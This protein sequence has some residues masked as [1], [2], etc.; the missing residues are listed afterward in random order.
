MSSERKTDSFSRR[1]G[2]ETPAG[3][4]REGWTVP[5]PEKLPRRTPWPVAAALGIVLVLW[6]A[7]TAVLVAAVG[8]AL[9]GIAVLGWIGEVRRAE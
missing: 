5:R 8:L 1:P 9:L 2:S 7:V 6:G 3:R 4:M